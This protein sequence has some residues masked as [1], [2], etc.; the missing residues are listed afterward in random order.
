MSLLRY[1]NII[2]MGLL[3]YGIYYIMLPTVCCFPAYDLLEV[4][5]KAKKNFGN[6]GTVLVYVAL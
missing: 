1:H 4:S 3:T 5:L 6:F 2:F